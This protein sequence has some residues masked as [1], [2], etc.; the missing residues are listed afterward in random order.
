MT[1]VVEAFEVD[2][3]T[4]LVYSHKEEVKVRDWLPKANITRAAEICFREA[5][6]KQKEAKEF[7]AT[8]P[9]GGKDERQPES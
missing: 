2:K 7:A 4:G 3:K 1:I 5:K 6:R 8:V 9:K